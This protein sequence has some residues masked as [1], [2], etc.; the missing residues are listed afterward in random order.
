VR[1]LPSHRRRFLDRLA[2]ILWILSLQTLVVQ[3]WA[4]AA[5]PTPFSL[6]F[7]TI[8]DLG[9]TACM[10]VDRRRFPYVCSPM[11]A[12]MNAS[13]IVFGMLWSVGATFF[14]LTRRQPFGRPAIAGAFFLAGIGARLVAD[15][16]EN[17]VSAVHTI[18]AGSELIFGS[19]GFILSGLR[20]LDRQ[21]TAGVMSIALGVGSCLA[22]ALFLFTYEHVGRAVLGLELGGWERVAFWSQ[23]LWLAAAGVWVLARE[24]RP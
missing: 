21:R 3:F 15:F 16:P 10:D 18:G 4:Q 14:F 8:S 12:A 13:F 19:I 9:A 1:E 5:W 11:H 6:N 2:A 17:T 20:L 23:N 22:F 7:N 24:D